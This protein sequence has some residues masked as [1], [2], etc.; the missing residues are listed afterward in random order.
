[1]SFQQKDPLGGGYVDTFTAQLGAPAG[2]TNEPQV[3]G[4][5]LGSVIFNSMSIMI[6]EKEESPVLSVTFVKSLHAE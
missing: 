1:M 2:T 5:E 6:F 3:P 4:G